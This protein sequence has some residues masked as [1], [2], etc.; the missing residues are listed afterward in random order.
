[1]GVRSRGG[2]RGLPGIGGFAAIPPLTY[3]ANTLNG[4]AVPYT[5]LT[6]LPAQSSLLASACTLIVGQLFAWPFMLSERTRLDRLAV[7]VDVGAGGAV[8]R[9]G[10]YANNVLGYRGDRYPGALLIDCG[11]FTANTTPQQRI[12]NV[13]LTLDAEQI[14]WAACQCGVAGPQITG[15]TASARPL[16]M[17]TDPAGNPGLA[18]T[19][20]RLARAYAA[21]PNPFGAGGAVQNSDRVGAIFARATAP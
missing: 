8:L 3:A 6:A 5:S 18:P 4:G 17:W 10:I 14:Y 7:N 2:P 21:L 19:N 13:D 20:I 1:M 9:F 12:A 11:E 16:L 15:H